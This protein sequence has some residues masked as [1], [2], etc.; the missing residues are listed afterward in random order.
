MPAG[1]LSRFVVR[2]I[3]GALR[4]WGLGKDDSGREVV[5]GQSLALVL[6]ALMKRDDQIK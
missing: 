5:L 4:D 1:T 6:D 3:L 2:S